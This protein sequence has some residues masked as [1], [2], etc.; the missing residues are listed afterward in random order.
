[1]FFARL[2]RLART[3]GFRIALWHS[4]IFI[5]GAALVFS[6]AFLLLR[7]SVDEQS[8]DAIEFRL[9]QF[10][11]EYERGGKD[12]IIELCKLRKGR[13]Q[14]AFFVRIGDQEN[15]TVFLRDG[16]DW[17]EFRPQRLALQPIPTQLA[18]TDLTDSENTVLRV[19]TARMH[20]GTVLQVGKTMEASR[21][22]LDRFRYALVGIAAIIILAG[23]AGGAAAAFRALRPANQLTA[24]VRSI[25]D[26]G[27][28]T[29]RVPSRGTGDEIDELVQC[30][31][32]MLGKIDVLIHGMRDSLDNVAHDLRTPMTRLRNIA[33]KAV[34]QDYSKEAALDAL[35]DCLEESERVLTMLVTLMDIA[36]AETGTMKLDH[37]PVNVAG[38]VAQVVDL[39]EHVAEEKRITIAVEVPSVLQVS[40]DAGRLQRALGNLMDNALK[41]TPED[42][43]IM[44]RAQHR[45][46]GLVL[47]VSD[48]GDGISKDELNRIWE[49]LYRVDKSR[50]QRGLGLGLSFV[51]AIVEAHGGRVAVESEVGR[52]SRFT[53]ELP[54]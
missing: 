12:A 4:V 36:E 32:A 8:H 28:F 29:A 14:K 44:V 16:D 48:T 7:R 23:A 53:M 50:S 24:T 21:E 40:G 15:R 18:W 34:E 2:R 9:N 13:A 3:V 30:F 52:G 45:E 37:Q 20:D 54:D 35:G 42:G 47:E 26:T 6:V 22:L 17:A 49:R 51:K 5:V 33:T 1:M 11:A 19:A 27:K 39:Y 41:Y 43:R 25:L 46:Q 31:N 10:T 38:L